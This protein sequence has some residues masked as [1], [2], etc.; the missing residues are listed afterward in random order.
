MK[1][2]IPF[3]V[4]LLFC[5]SAG[6]AQSTKGKN[7][8]VG[9]WK[10]EAPYA[11]EGY[12]TG[13]MEVGFADNK[14]TATISFTGSDYKIPGE[15][16]KIENDT[17]NFSVFLDGAEIPINLKMD[18]DTKMAGKAVSPEGEIPMTLTKEIPN[19]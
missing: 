19:L 18:G 1:K 4:L 11:P 15:K 10:F 16:V 5:F 14:Y 6:S 7:S 8:P 3:I 9:K 12:T 2:T 17:L 13:L